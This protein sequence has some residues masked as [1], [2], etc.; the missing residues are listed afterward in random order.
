MARLKFDISNSRFSKI[1]MHVV[2]TRNLDGPCTPELKPLADFGKLPRYKVHV[3]SL[4]AM[5]QCQQTNP[6]PSDDH[7]GTRE[8]LQT[9]SRQAKRVETP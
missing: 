3:I 6:H 4:A 2:D 1:K 7:L 5:L 8:L 9:H